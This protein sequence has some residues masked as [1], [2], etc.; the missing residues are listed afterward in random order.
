[1]MR[2]AKLVL[3]SAM[4]ALGGNT[5][6]EALGFD[7]LGGT[8][9]AFGE[10]KPGDYQKF[11]ATYRQWDVPPQIYAFDSIGGNVYEAIA[12]AHFIR[13]S[14]IPVWVTGK[15]YS[16]CAL[17]YLSAPKR[18]ASGEIGLH[19]TYFDPDY[20]AKLSSLDAEKEFAYLQETNPGGVGPR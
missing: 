6:A 7:R 16:S 11:I 18:Q 12:I 8:M 13:L 5:T 14:R 15:C 3:L 19:R 10:I 9:V 20:Y 1:M 2:I 4:I 17:I